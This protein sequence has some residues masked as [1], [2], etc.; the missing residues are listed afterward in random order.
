MTFIVKNKEKKRK[1]RRERGVYN[2]KIVCFN[3][4]GGMPLFFLKNFSFL[5]IK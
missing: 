1:K 4:G 2:N 5:F 3:M